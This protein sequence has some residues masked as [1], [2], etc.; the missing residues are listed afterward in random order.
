MGEMQPNTACIRPLEEHH[1]WRG[2][3]LRVFGQNASHWA[4]ES[5]RRVLI[6]YKSDLW[7]KT[8][9]QM[10]CFCAMW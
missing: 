10:N 7:R 8:V 6:K 2:G 5:L 1:G 9:C 3:L 4:A